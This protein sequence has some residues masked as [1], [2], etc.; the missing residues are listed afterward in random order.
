MVPEV[1]H[2]GYIVRAYGGGA[3]ADLLRRS[4]S[5]QSGGLLPGKAPSLPVAH[6]DDVAQE[7]Q[8]LAV[9]RL[10]GLGGLQLRAQFGNDPGIVAVPVAVDHHQRVRVGLAE[11]VL[12]FMD[13][14]GG[15][16]RHQHRADF[17]GGPEGDEPGGHVC[18]PDGHL[19]AAFDPQCDEGPGKLVHIV[20]ELGVGPGIVQSGVLERVLI[21]KLL[22][23]FVQHL[24]ESAV[25][26][27]VLF[28]HIPSRS[29]GVVVE[30]ALPAL[31]LEAGHIDGVV[32]QNHL[33]VVQS[34]HPC[35]VPDQGDE[36]VIVD[37][38]QGVHQL[39]HGQRALAHQLRGTQVRAVG[40]AH[41]AD[42]GP[43]VGDGLLGGL[44]LH[45]TGAVGVPAGGKMVAGEV[46]QHL[47]QFFRVGH[48][49]GTLQQKGD[50]VFFRQGNGG[51]ELF[52]D[53]PAIAAY[54]VDHHIGD[55]EV[56]RRLHGGGKLV[57]RL[58]SGQV[59]SRP[60]TGDGQVLRRQPAAGR[61]GQLRIRGAVSHGQEGV[62]HAV[63]LQAAE[64]G[65]GSGLTGCGPVQF[66][67][68]FHGKR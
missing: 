40:K 25:N 7:G 24:R 67:P 18:G 59:G 45:Q 3:A 57:L 43:Q 50:V 19:V 15:V 60:H 20:P 35:G 30:V 1:L 5:R 65:A 61:R 53:L 37:A 46:I 44:L 17:C 27:D 33:R 29:G 49:A 9:E 22:R 58:G 52:D 23:H 54:G 2:I 39:P 42:V 21:R 62:L 31:P 56:C 6:G 16:Y 41:M 48:G 10:A 4:L 34:L 38:A 28:P 32:G 68:V 63:D 13:F 64:L 66:G 8:T 26:N 55:Q 51:G 47:H 12:R 14:I 36:A 11:E